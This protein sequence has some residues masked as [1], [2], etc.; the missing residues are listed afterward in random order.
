[1]QSIVQRLAQQGATEINP[2][3]WL[4]TLTIYQFELQGWLKDAVCE[5]GEKLKSTQQLVDNR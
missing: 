5:K 3:F 4:D 2:F 1:M